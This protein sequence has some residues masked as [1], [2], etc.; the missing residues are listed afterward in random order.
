[1]EKEK[2]LGEKPMRV[3]QCYFMFYDEVPTYRDEEQYG[4][5]YIKVQ[6]M[7]SLLDAFGYSLLYTSEEEEPKRWYTPN[8]YLELSNLQV[9]PELDPCI[10]AF[11][12]ELY[13]KTEE[14]I[15]EYYQEGLERETY[16]DSEITAR[17]GGLV[18]EFAST[19][20]REIVDVLRD[21]TTPKSFKDRVE[22]GDYGE[23]LQDLMEYVKDVFFPVVT[24]TKEYSIHDSRYLEFLRKYIKPVEPNKEKA[25]SY[26]E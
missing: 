18:R 3:L 14:E 25:N 15:Q 26:N 10:Q 4:D 12:Q 5:F 17:I 21:L 8:R 2:M 23:D 6:A 24:I 22:F 11:N 20:N 13:G 9:S 16:Y 1:M 19:R 7:M